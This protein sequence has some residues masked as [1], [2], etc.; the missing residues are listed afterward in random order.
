MKL[1]DERVTDKDHPRTST[2]PELTAT[3]SELPLDTA[4][5]N[6]GT[7]R[8]DDIEELFWLHCFE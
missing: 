1:F 5:T 8:H 6:D 3:P 4:K 7:T 2:P